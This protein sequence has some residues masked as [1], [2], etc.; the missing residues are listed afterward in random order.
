VPAG[1]AKQ[2]MLSLASLLEGER[3]SNEVAFRPYAPADQQCCLEIFDRN[4]PEFF[5]PN[6]RA[7]YVSFLAACPD[8]YEV[9]CIGSAVVGACGLIGS[10]TESRNLNWILLASNLQGAGIGS[11][12]MRRVIE[13][14]R[15]LRLKHIRIAASHKSAAFFARFGAVATQSITDG[16]GPGMHRMDM[17]LRLTGDASLE[18]GA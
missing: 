10:D 17:E 13:A 11:T 14:A 6:E 12:M 5:S 18:G 8:N 15:A 9:C 1:S 3:M 16:W 2:G 4:C 7:D